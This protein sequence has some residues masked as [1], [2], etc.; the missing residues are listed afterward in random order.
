MAQSY[1]FGRP[2]RISPKDMWSFRTLLQDDIKLYILSF[3]RI[4]CENVT[5]S[6][7]K[8]ILE[9]LK[10]LCKKKTFEKFKF[11]ST[12]PPVSQIYTSFSYLNNYSNICSVSEIQFKIPLPSFS[13]LQKYNYRRIAKKNPELSLRQCQWNL[14]KISYIHSLKTLDEIIEMW[15]SVFGYRPKSEHINWFLFVLSGFE[16]VFLLFAWL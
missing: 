9:I 2:N 15:L 6:V 5:K 12:Q 16:F 1:K 8:F 7:S 4:S 10:C 14:L 3:V 11:N 13:R